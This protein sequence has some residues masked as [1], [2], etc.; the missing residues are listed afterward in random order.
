MTIHDQ[1]NSQRS[2]ETR[3]FYVLQRTSVVANAG[4]KSEIW[5]DGTIR[6]KRYF[7]LKAEELE[8]ID[9]YNRFLTGNVSNRPKTMIRLT[10]RALQERAVFDHSK[11][12]WPQNVMIFLNGI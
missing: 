11:H 12:A 7:D 1:M 5:K 2:V 3:Q 9:E 8:E 6:T 4:H 10:C